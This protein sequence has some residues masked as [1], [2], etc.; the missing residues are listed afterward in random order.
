MARATAE[1]STTLS[2]RDLLTKAMMT[3][4]VVALAAA[5]TVAAVKLPHHPDAE[6]LAAWNEHAAIWHAMDALPR[7]EEHNDEH[8]HLLEDVSPPI[9]EK[10]ESIPATTAQGI[11][12]KL[13]YLLIAFTESR[14]AEETVFLGRDPDKDELASDY[15]FRMLFDLIGDVQK[16]GA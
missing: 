11:A 4:P 3:A 8:L 14:W 9:C 7:D 2:R 1:N 12:I 10:I 13:Q 6:L 15:R 16:M 5:G